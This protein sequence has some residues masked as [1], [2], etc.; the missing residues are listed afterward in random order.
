MIGTRRP[1]DGLSGSMSKRTKRVILQIW[2]AGAYGRGIVAGVARYIQTREH[3]EFY[4]EPNRLKLEEHLGAAD[5]FIGNVSSPGDID[6]FARHGIA[7]VNISNRVGGLTCPSSL[8][9]DE[10]V[11]AMAAEHLLHRG[12]SRFAYCGFTGHAYSEGRGAAFTAAL[13]THGRQAI[14]YSPPGTITKDSAFA[15]QAA[16]LREWVSQLPAPCGVFCCNDNRAW[17]VIEACRE[18]GVAVPE[19][20]AVLGV[21][22]DELM[23]NLIRPSIS[24]IE[25]PLQRIGFEA[26][27]LLGRLMRGLKPPRNPL[28]LPPG[29]VVPRRSTE[30][31]AVDDADV[32]AAVR[33][34]REHLTAPL[35]IAEIAEAIGLAK[36]TL[37]RRFKQVMGRTIDTE[38]RMARIRH[39][40]DLLAQTDLPMPAVA[41]AS[42]FAYAEHLA[43]V[44]RRETG[45]T[46]TGYRKQYRLGSDL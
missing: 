21:D 24:S 6:L 25:L 32:A 12:F 23:C 44:F 2:L 30:V 34:I 16:H 17:Q 14:H 11:G 18:A 19:S 7:A 8:P 26:A 27:A 22:N 10:T 43:T 20:L 9:D 42:G 39:A 28:R 4:V 29:G 5:G 3:W 31:L 13:A 35:K 33:Y 41:E 45:M 36:R 38:V 15:D 46:P 40:R 1:C 37:Q